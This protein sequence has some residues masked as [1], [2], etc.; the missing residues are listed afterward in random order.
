MNRILTKS[1]WENLSVDTLTNTLVF[2]FFYIF[3]CF[4]LVF[5]VFYKFII[6]VDFL[7]KYKNLAGGNQNTI[8]LFVCI[9]F[10]DF[11]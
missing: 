4:L 5:V 8:F 11:W 9:F 3:L 10:Y 2:L 1:P 7:K 6:N